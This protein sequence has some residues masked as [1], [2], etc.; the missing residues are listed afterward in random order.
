MLLCDGTSNEVKQDLINVLKLY[1][2]AVRNEEQLVFYDPGIGT[3]G[4]DNDWGRARQALASLF[5]LATGWGLDDNFPDAYV[6]LCLEWREGDRIHLFDF[7]RGAN[8][9]RAVAGLV[10]LLGI[11]RPEQPNLVSYALTAYKRSPSQRSL[12]IAWQF[13]RVIGGRRAPIHFLGVWDTY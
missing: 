10:Y 11:L 1:R 13:Q 4:L 3:I 9:P 12:E 8:T 5:G 6:F 2:I 7:S